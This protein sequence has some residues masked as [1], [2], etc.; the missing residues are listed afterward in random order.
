VVGTFGCCCC[1]NPQRQAEWSSESKFDNWHGCDACGVWHRS[2][3]ILERVGLEYEQGCNIRNGEKE[4]NSDEDQNSSQ[5][6][7]SPTIP[8]GIAVVVAAIISAR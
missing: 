6:P 5:D 8:S 3:E 2:C 1:S 7:S 4:D